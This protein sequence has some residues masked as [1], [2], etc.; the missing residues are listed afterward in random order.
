M[1]NN[2]ALKIWKTK[3]TTALNG[4][5]LKKIEQQVN[6]GKKTA[7]QRLEILLD[8]ESFQEVDQLAA[9]PFLAS[10]L[11]TDG[12][13]AGF[14]MVAGKKVAVYAQDFTI[15][16]GSLGKRHAEKI[17][18]VMDMAAKIGCPIIGIIDS[19]GARIDE[20]IHALAGYG[21]IFKRNVHYSGVV[22]QISLILGPCAGGAA[23]SPAL[24][25]FVFMT[26][27]ISQMFI[28]GPQVIKEVLGQT[29]TKEEL[30]GSHVHANL[31]G[32]AHVVTK[33]EAEC[34][35]KLKNL[36][37]LLPSNYLDADTGIPYNKTAPSTSIDSLIPTAETSGYDVKTIILALVDNETFFE[38]HEH[39]ATNIVVGLA[40][41]TG[42]TVGIVANQPLHKAGT[43]DSDASVKAARF[44][45]FCN[46]FSIPIISLVDV[47]GFLPGIQEEHDG[48]IRHGAKLLYAYANATVPKIT[49]IMRKA[50]GG[51]YIVM[52]SK[53]MGADFNFAWPSAQIAVL[54]PQAAIAIL[55]GKTLA[56]HPQEER[57]ALQKVL[58]A[59]YREEYLHP[60]IAAENGFIDAIIEPNDTRQT[61]IKALGIAESKVEQLP[62]KKNGNIPL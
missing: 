14:G 20:G 30:G 29:I 21:S 49:V 16:G 33:N 8:S 48:I 5:D 59:T 26:E 42:K 32:V 24:T 57:P 55:H 43:I 25:D 2:H 9:S 27:Q 31:S 61:L 23:Y 58:E 6:A 41:L 40:R 28:T 52:G 15:K 18:K 50:F 53:E 37:S 10:K 39:F 3:E 34:F 19:G 51:A 46:N 62:K 38:I 1:I 44:I 45:Q 56:S 47:P 54:G 4:S 60:Y 35:E 13:I 22:P 17:C 12:V 11:Y 36:L 7:R